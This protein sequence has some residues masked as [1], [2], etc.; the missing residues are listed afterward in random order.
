MP[1][2]ETAL[3]A[4]AGDSHQLAPER[5]DLSDRVL[6]RLVAGLCI[7]LVAYLLLKPFLPEAW[8]R[9]GSPMLQSAAIVGSLMLLSP[10]AFWLGKR[11]GLSAVPNRLYVIHVIASTAGIF[12]V[13]IHAFAGF[14]GP[15]LFIV[16]CLVL[17]VVT[18]FIGRVRLSA[19]MA[20]T[21]GSKSAAFRPVPA[22]LKE[23][24]RDIIRQK[25]SLLQRLDPQAQEALFSVTL[26]HWIRAPR[27]S[28]AYQRLA[29]KEARLTGQRASVPPVQAWWRL[30]HILL[31]WAFLIALLT[32]AALVTFLPGYVAGDG[33]VYWWHLGG[34]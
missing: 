19:P 33:E 3:P 4:S 21:F 14:R 24:I 20:A 31:A 1:L 7:G 10:F 25:A 29:L 30:L 15:P 12:L 34:T 18:G 8:H 11:T 17:L 2:K 5:P 27:L 13:A 9:P 22:H 16:F 6:I 26:H 28:L 32:H 23:E